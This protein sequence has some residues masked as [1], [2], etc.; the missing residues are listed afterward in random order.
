MDNLLFR[1]FPENSTLRVNTLRAASERAKLYIIF[2]TPRSGSTWLTEL[3]KNAEAL[4]IPQE[5]FN[6]TWIYSE[7]EA[8][9]CRP[10]RLR[11]TLDIN[12]YVNSIVN[13]CNGI[14]GIELSAYQAIMLRDLLDTNFDPQILSTSFYLR[15]RDIVSQ[16]V[17]LYRS[18]SSSRFHSYQNDKHTVD[19]FNSV[20]YRYNGILES[21]NMILDSERIFSELFAECNIIPNYIFYE[22]LVSDPLAEL[23]KIGW[24]LGTP[25]QS[26]LPM[27]SLSIM[28]DT[29]S[30][31]WASQFTSE[32]PS[33]IF[34]IIQEREARADLRPFSPP[35]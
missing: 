18:I 27:T 21:L 25:Y 4:G 15:R 33:E 35:A 6:D 22:D 12:D 29:R 17:S 30:A 31:S 20:E 32:L 24:T 13:E 23:N 3:I 7:E 10:P 34:N 8:L 1:A 2:M 5:W 28:R 9:G 11:G 19:L 26:V 14:A 16:A